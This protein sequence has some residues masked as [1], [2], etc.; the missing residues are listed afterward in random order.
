MKHCITNLV[1]QHDICVPMNAANK[2][3]VLFIFLL[4]EILFTAQFYG[5]ALLTFDFFSPKIS[6]ASNSLTTY[7]KGTLQKSS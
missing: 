7:D 6:L 3:S 2:L 4:Y 1:G 5:I